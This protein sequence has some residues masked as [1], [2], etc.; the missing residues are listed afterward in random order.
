MEVESNNVSCFL[1][2][3]LG[4]N[5]SESGLLDAESENQ[6]AQHLIFHYFPF[7]KHRAQLGYIYVSGG[8][9]GIEQCIMLPSWLL[10]AKSI[11]IWAPRR[12]IRKSDCSASYL[13]L[14]S[15]RKA[16]STARID[17]REWRR[18][19]I[20]PH[21]TFDAVANYATCLIRSPLV[22]NGS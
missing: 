22:S 17:A 18:K 13:P 14:F 12:G 3:Y 15:V 10:G 20:M 9:G 19:A 11:R 8:G 2:G 21:S 4:P 16:Q 6:I 5:P 7:R 1:H